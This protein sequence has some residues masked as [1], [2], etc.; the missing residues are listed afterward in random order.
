MPVARKPAP[1]AEHARTVTAAAAAR[2]VGAASPHNGKA[3]NCNPQ[4]PTAIPAPQQ[5]KECGCSRLPVLIASPAASCPTPSLPP[6]AAREQPWGVRREF[7]FQ[8]KKE[9][10]VRYVSRVRGQWFA[11]RAKVEGLGVPTRNGDTPR[12]SVLAGGCG[13]AACRAPCA[14]D[15]PRRIRARFATWGGATVVA[16][17]TQ[18][19]SDPSRPVKSCPIPPIPLLKR[20]EDRSSSVAMPTTALDPSSSSSAKSTS[21]SVISPASTRSRIKSTNNFVLNRR[22]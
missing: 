10:L 17:S 11:M 14:P 8:K 13:R 5:P 21:S 7:F 18:S 2:V 19:H 22:S 9:N 3:R 1:A 12:Q 20:T 16:P 15:T 4:G 6:S